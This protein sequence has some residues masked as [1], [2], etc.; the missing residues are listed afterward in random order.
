MIAIFNTDLEAIIFII[1]IAIGLVLINNILN[2]IFRHIKQLSIKY[3]IIVNFSF[4]IVSV[5]IVLYFIIEGIPSFQEID[6]AYQIILTGSITTAIAFSSSGIFTNLVSGIILII[7]R[8]FDIGD[9]VKIKGNK[10]I[11]RSINLTS[12][13]I[14]T[15]DYILIEKSNSEV[16]SSPIINYT[17]KLGKIKSFEEFEKLVQS[18]LDRDIFLS[19]KQVIDDKKEF[20]NE[21]REFYNNISK[22]KTP[23]LY[24]YTFRMAFPYK[25]FRVMMDQVEKLCKEYRN[26][27]IFRLRPRFHI[28]DIGFKIT[29]KFKILTLYSE[30]IFNYQSQLTDDVYKI[31]YAQK[32]D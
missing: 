2:F 11:V 9:L 32:S 14:E 20:E 30:K 10:G 5:L 27:G 28:I 23:N 7:I 6:P 16:I 13:V 3:K 24:A 15:F 18:P 29:V 19:E 12:T 17:I 22:K 1:I 26:N 31:I 25:R 21:L 8:P 4:R